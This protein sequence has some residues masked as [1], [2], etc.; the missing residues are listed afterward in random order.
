MNE[1]SAIGHVYEPLDFPREHRHV[2]SETN[3]DNNHNVLNADGTFSFQANGPINIEQRVYNLVED[4]SVV[5]TGEAIHTST[6]H[7]ANEGTNNGLN[8]GINGGFRDDTEKAEPI[9]Y[10]IEEPSVETTGQPHAY[11]DHPTVDPIYCALEEICSQVS[12]QRLNVEYP[13][14]LATSL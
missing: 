14:L 13:V 1:D 5:S 4:L 6:N 8:Y 9:Y 3:T 11:N 2:S 12:T 10:V 7:G